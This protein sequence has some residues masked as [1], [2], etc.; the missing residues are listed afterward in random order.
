MR[1]ALLSLLLVTLG[2]CGPSVRNGSELGRIRVDAGGHKLELLVEGTDQGQPTVILES[3]LG[4]SI[5]SWAA[6]RQSLSKIT[7][8]V[9]YHRAGN[10]GSQPGPRPR[11][12][13]RVAQELRTALKN[14]NIAPPYILVGHSIGGLY[15]R[16]YAATYADEIAG[17]VL[18]DP[19]MEFIESLDRSQ[20]DA[21]LKQ[22]WATEYTRVEKTLGRVHPKMSLI[23]A[24]SML[25]LERYLAQVPLEEQA[26]NRSKWL[27]KFETHIQQLEGKLVLLSNAE[28][29][30]LF[31]STESM[32]SVRDSPPTAVPVKLLIAEKV[33]APSSE[34]GDANDPTKSA[35]YIQW[36]QDARKLRYSEFIATIP[37]GQLLSLPDSGHNVPKDRPDAIVD[38]VANLISQSSNMQ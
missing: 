14:L 24:H 1:S 35:K 27:S 19:T 8:V 7:K 18:V 34:R 36:A 6:V 13:S 20:I 26:A 30:E 21:R 16:R 28:R 29:Q 11:S 23:A 4:G 2:A 31:A 12:A 33:S 15:V 25:G 5:E 37:N 22:L 3:A 9:S 10:G 32:H 17:L 38:A